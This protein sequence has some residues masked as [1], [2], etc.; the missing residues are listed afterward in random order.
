MAYLA[1]YL[2][3]LAVFLLLDAVWLK[4]VMRP[5]FEAHVGGLLRDEIRLGPAAGFYLAYVG[6]ILYF[7]S[8][9][10]LAGGG[11]LRSALDGML[12]GFLAYGTYEATNLATL[13]GWRWSMALTD[14][15]WGMALTALTAAAG[16]LA[17]RWAGLG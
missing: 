7:A 1:V 6:G 10:A 4:R 8:L 15:G 11:V 13:R 3:A 17:A 12:L 2:A 5:L 14:T 16:H 9:P